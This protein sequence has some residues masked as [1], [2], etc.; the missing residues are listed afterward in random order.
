M[1]THLG[2]PIG[3]HVTVM[4]DGD[5]SGEVC[6]DKLFR[7]SAAGDKSTELFVVPPLNVL[8]VTDLGWRVRYNAQNVSAPRSVHLDISV[9]T[10][11]STTVFR[12]RTLAIVADAHSWYATSEQLTGGFLAAPGAEICARARTL[13]RSDGAPETDAFSLRSLVLRGYFVFEQPR[14]TLNTPR[15]ISRN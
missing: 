4:F 5:P 6:N 3:R 1:L 14:A 13:G 12:S 9:G 15:G 7:V 2:Q 8:V 10:N 11:F